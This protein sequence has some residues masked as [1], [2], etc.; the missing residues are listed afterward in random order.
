[1][2]Q[3]AR[4]DPDPRI[5][6]LLLR[7]PGVA[8][9]RVR[10]ADDGV[11]EAR[12]LPTPGRSRM[13]AQGRCALIDDGGTFVDAEL[14]DISWAGVCVRLGESVEVP[15]ELGAEVQ[16]WIEAEALG[17]GVDGW[18]GRVRWVRDRDVGVAFEGNADEGIPLLQLVEAFARVSGR[19]TGFASMASR[20]PL[21]AS[22]D[23]RAVLHV[24]SVGVEARTVDIA[25]TGVGLELV[26]PFHLDLRTRDVHV[27]I[28]ATRLWD[29]PFR[30]TVVRHEGD[31]VGLALR[32][33]LPASRTL[34]AMTERAA[35][36]DSVSPRA[37]ADWLR[38]SGLR[39]TVRVL[40]VAAADLVAARG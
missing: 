34:A 36:E 22:F 33:D 26:E 30:A 29:E 27:Q 2:P 4:L 10:V 8:A 13:A 3:A 6:A 24:G 40:H 20:R 39:E 9:V 11:A 14:V 35:A 18:L 25:A 15:P 5:A 12:V 32:H 17:G 1:M 19:T 7:H 37:L 16:L 21:R 28:D 31:R 23:R 38:G